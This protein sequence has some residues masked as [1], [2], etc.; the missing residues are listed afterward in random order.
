MK[1]EVLR[2]AKKNPS[3]RRSLILK[4]GG[5]SKSNRK[6]GDVWQTS[7]GYRA[8]NSNG[9]SKTFKKQEDAKAF[10]NSKNSK[11]GPKPSEK[12]SLG[13]AMSDLKKRSK[14][15]KKMPKEEQRQAAKDLVQLIGQIK[16]HEG[17]KTPLYDE[18][19]KIREDAAQAEAED[20]FQEYVK[21]MKKAGQK[22]VLPWPK[23]PKSSP[24]S[25]SLFFDPKNE[26]E[27]KERRKKDLEKW[28][29]VVTDRHRFF[30]DVLGGLGPDVQKV[31]D[32]GLRVIKDSK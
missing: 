29:E 12:I 23:P 32:K 25:S 13:D 21:E 28:K 10:A 17:D 14:S 1:N 24:S 30:D 11:E 9:V 5:R 16:K 2:L 19:Y 4:M 31:V 3:F 18:I 6:P 15:F 27:G 7:T 22:I 8:M 26:R 20:F